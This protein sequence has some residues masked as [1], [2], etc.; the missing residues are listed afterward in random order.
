MKNRKY[1]DEEGLPL[2]QGVYL[3]KSP[4]EEELSRIDVYLH[5]RKGLCC[6][7]DDFGSSG[8]GVDDHHD[9]HVSIQFTGLAFIAWA[10]NIKGVG[11]S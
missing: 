2:R 11:N 7:A 1:I 9:C 5:P 4:D 8:S 3:V 6:F 10:G